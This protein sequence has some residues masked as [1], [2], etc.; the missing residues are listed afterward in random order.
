MIDS[1]HSEGP[2]QHYFCCSVH[3]EIPNL[4]LMLCFWLALLL[5]LGYWFSRLSQGKVETKKII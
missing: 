3:C 4:L 1:S 5:L 2:Y